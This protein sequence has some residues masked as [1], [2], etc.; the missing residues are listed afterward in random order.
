MTPL[1][2]A[3]PPADP[4]GDTIILQAASASLPTPVTV[5][6]LA[7]RQALANW[8][9]PRLTVSWEAHF[10]QAGTYEVFMEFGLQTYKAEFDLTAGKARMRGLVEMTG[11]LETFK[12]QKVGQIEIAQPGRTVVTLRPVA[13]RWRALGL[14]SLRFRRAG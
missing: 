5:H 10:S 6:S 9:D 4:G 13:A 3:Q 1:P 8:K 14:A 12:T 7:G 11:S 2:V